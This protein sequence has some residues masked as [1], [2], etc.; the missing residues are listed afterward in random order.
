MWQYC[1]LDKENEKETWKSDPVWLSLRNRAA[2]S[3][4]TLFQYLP[5]EERKK[6]RQKKRSLKEITASSV[7]CSV[8]GGQVLAVSPGVTSCDP[9]PELQSQKTRYVWPVQPLS[10]GL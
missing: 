4:K 5:S 10:L 9:G 2:G 7:P 8:S 6:E 1:E 3:L